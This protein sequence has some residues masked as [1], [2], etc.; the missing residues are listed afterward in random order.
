MDKVR[1]G[2]VGVGNMGSAHVKHVLENKISRCTLT[3]VCD[4]DLSRVASLNGPAKFATAEQLIGT[5]LLDRRGLF[6]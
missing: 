2:I 6:W 1:L 5:N 4:H 3:A